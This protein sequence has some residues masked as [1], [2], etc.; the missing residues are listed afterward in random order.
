MEPPTRL[1]IASLRDKFET[2]GTIMDM[3]RG[4]S[5]GLRTSISEASSLA[6]LDSFS[7]SPQN[8]TSQC[9]SETCVR[10]LRNEIESSTHPIP[11]ATLRDVPTMYGIELK[12][13][14]DEWVTA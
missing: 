7:R 4:R 6:M 14:G 11:A 13:F 9:A 5:V 12:M 8:W 1:S 3:H 10:G 2:D